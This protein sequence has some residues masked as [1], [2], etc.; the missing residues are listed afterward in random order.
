VTL[1]TRLSVFLLLVLG[2]V[3]AGFSATL[4]LLAR[5]HLYQQVDDRLNWALDTLK[6]AAEMDP[7]GIEWEPHEH[8]LTL[9]KDTEDSRVHWRVNDD[10]GRRVDGCLHSAAADILAQAASKPVP[11]GLAAEPEYWH[12]Q[13]WRLARRRLQSP[14]GPR[15]ATSDE[16]RHPPGKE[17]P[18]YPA[19]VLTAALS[20]EPVH[21]TL[22][23]L[24]WALAGT[25]TALWLLTLFVGRW[26]CRRALLPVTR[27]ATTA[28]T[29][30]AADLDRRL[31]AADTGDELAELGRVFN[32]LLD[33]LQESFERQRRF[34]GDASHQL[35]TPLAAMLGQVEVTL[36][37]E[38]T[39]EE[40]RRA[41]TLVQAQAG[42]LC[43]IVEMLLF[44]ARADAEARLPCLEGLELGEWLSEYRTFWFDHSRAAD[45]AWEASSTGPAWAEVHAPL[46]SQVLDILLENACKYS[47]PGTPITA[48]VIVESGEVQLAVIDRGCGI[49]PD[50]LPHIFEPFYRSGQARRSGVPG[51]GLG[52]A[53]AQ[54]ITAAFGG[55]LTVQSE[56]G[57]GSCFT[58]RLL[59]S[60]VG[61]Q[62]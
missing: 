59:P 34:T 12:D 10:C 27:M 4:Y 42:H 55:R 7:A 19:L 44:L 30:N 45:L 14:L 43:R 62:G 47:E 35:R 5:A 41:L 28:A 2:V 40:Y 49:A 61:G 39:P 18:K 53:I 23:S 46:L 9:G 60:Q 25:S 37:R 32:G 24:A 13:T 54:R 50:D 56:A 20:L 29:M 33:R 57:K 26:L 16:K 21:T 1:T 38:R 48:R 36:R 22:R 6:A 52:L 15:V 31:P 11:G 3:L 17:P 51:V 58:L 8:L